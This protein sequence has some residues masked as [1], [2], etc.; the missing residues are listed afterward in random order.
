MGQKFMS[1]APRWRRGAGEPARPATFSL[2][3]MMNSVGGSVSHYG[4]WLRRF[5]PRHFKPLARVR[6]MWGL[7]ALPEGCTLADWPVSYDELE[8]YYTLVERI[9]GV[10]GL[11]LTEGVDVR[12]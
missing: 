3:R 6:E 12:A 9:A 1:E 4:A 11:G 10:A 7:G 5:H 2:G 8:P